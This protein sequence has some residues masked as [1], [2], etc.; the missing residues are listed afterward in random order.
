MEY[1]KQIAWE[2]QLQQQQVQAQP[3]Q[4][5]EKQEQLEKEEQEEEEQPEEEE[6]EEDLEE[7]TIEEA[8]E[9]SNDARKIAE[10]LERK[11]QQTQNRV[12]L[13]K[14]KLDA[15]LRQAERHL[16]FAKCRALD[17]AFI[18]DCCRRKSFASCEVCSTTIKST[19]QM[20]AKIFFCSADQQGYKPVCWDCVI[21]V[22]SDDDVVCSVTGCDKRNIHG[23]NAEPSRRFA[24]YNGKLFCPKH[25]RSDMALRASSAAC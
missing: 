8:T 5:E 21:G 11:H 13:A 12:V 2:R 22:G 20:A 25:I 1:M 7:P 10:E 6:S 23:A 14:E 18:E 16:S 4:P 24:T 9:A 17:A 19:G 3:D 15:E